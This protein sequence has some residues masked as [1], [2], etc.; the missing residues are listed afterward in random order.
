MSREEILK[1]EL[2]NDML[3]WSADKMYETFGPWLETVINIQKEKLQLKL[4]TI[5]RNRRWYAFRDTGE[6]FGADTMLLYFNQKKIKLYSLSQLESIIE[7][8]ERETIYSNPKTSK[9]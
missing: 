9:R 7:K 5:W 1:K 6:Q 4:K 8:I 3:Q 2:I